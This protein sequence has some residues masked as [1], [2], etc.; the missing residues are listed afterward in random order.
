MRDGTPT[1][2]IGTDI[3]HGGTLFKR[4]LEDRQICCGQLLRVQMLAYYFLFATRN[5]IY[6]T[7]CVF[8]GSFPVRDRFL[9]RKI[10]PLEQV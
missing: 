6:S 2:L 3:E 8:S 7:S 4:E 10:W 5:V 1:R 9:R